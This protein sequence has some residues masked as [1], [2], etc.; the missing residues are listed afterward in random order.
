[1]TR[2]AFLLSVALGALPL[3][4][5]TPT[6]ALT[7]KV[8]GKDNQPVDRAS[9]IIRF[10]EGHS[11]AKFGKAVKDQYELKTNQEG[12]AR[13]PPIPQG[14]IQLQV[15]APKYQTYGNMY[16]LSED[17]KMIEIHLNPPQSQYSAHE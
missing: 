17:Q 13:I 5:R 9:V 7:I 4:A 14:K 16:D 15:I 12:I 2:K 6:T 8:T 3:A 10:V 1:M 11:K